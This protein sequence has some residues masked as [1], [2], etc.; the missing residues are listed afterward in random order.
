MDR[1]RILKDLEP[2]MDKQ[3]VCANLVT[4]LF[5][6]PG[7]YYKFHTGILYRVELRST[8]Q[9]RSITKTFACLWFFPSWPILFL[10]SVVLVYTVLAEELKRG[11]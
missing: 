11:R 5:L 2:H 3:S 7:V 4:R 1:A 6:R 8:S 9:R 10:F